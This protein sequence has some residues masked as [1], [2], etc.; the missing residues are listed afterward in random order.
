MGKMTNGW[1]VLTHLTRH[2]PL[3]YLPDK[4]CLSISFKAYQGYF[5]DFDNPTTFNEKLQWLKL[6]DRNPIYTKLSD[7]FLVRDYIADKIGGKYLIPLLGVWNSPN[8]I[9]YRTLPEQFVLKCNH[10]SGSVVICTDKSKLD[11]AETNSKLLKGLHTDYYLKSREYNYKD[12]PRKIIAER[13][14]HNNNNDELTDYKFFCFDGIPRFI[15]VDT[16][17]FTNHV[18]NFYDTSWNFIDVRYGCKN[19]IVDVLPEP[20]RLEEMLRLAH[21]L[22]EGFPHVRVDFYISN[23]EIYFGELTF[24]HGGGFM[25]LDPFEYDI[26]WGKFLDLPTKNKPA[27]HT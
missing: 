27:P 4:I 22:S 2:F 10:D 26:E 14:M 5:L 9:D 24:H 25:K 18:R 11:I 20:E 7:K 15:Q 12:I 16:G 19:S 1:L 6:Y 3:K 13:L 23:G 21:V 17:R 8:E